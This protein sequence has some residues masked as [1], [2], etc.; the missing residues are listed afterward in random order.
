MTFRPPPEEAAWRHQTARDGFEVVFLRAS[1]AGVRCRG[2][3]SAL[4]GGRAWFVEYVIELDAQWRTR[5]A[6]V[7]SQLGET[8]LVGD[9]LGHWRVDDQPAPLLD[10]CLD[11]DLESSSFTNAFPVHRLGLSVGQTAQTPAAYVRAPEL[12]VERLEQRYVRLPDEGAHTCFDYSAPSFEFESKLVY[13][14]FGLVLDYPGIA[15]RVV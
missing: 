12:Q 10:G 7:R 13:D 9:G 6:Q 15:L 1:P 2:C 14:Q 4:E 11:V 5:R 3:T 8:T